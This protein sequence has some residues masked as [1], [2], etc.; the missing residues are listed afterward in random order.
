M[1]AGTPVVDAVTTYRLSAASPRVRMADWFAHEGITA[2]WHTYA[3]TADVRPETLAAHPW[4]VLRA[5]RHV[6]SIASAEVLMLSREA[7][8]WSLG[9][10]EADLLARAGRGVYDVDDAIFDD[11]SPIRRLMRF[12]RKWARMVQ[13]A[14][15]VIAG[16]DY[17][18]EHAGRHA[19]DVRMIPSCIEP[20][21]YRAKTQWSVSEVPRV[22]WLGSP[23][24]EHYLV[25]LIE[26]LARLHDRTGARLTL[27]SGPG[28]RRDLAPLGHLVDRVAWDPAT[29]PALLAMGDVAIGPLD[30]SPYARGKCAYKLLQ[31][32][33]TGLPMVASPVGANALALARFDG[34]PVAGVDD[35]A[36]ALEGV[37]T[38]SE[39]R[40]AARGRR[41]LVAV[42]EHYAFAAWSSAWRD[43]VLGQPPDA[44][45][46]EGGSASS[47]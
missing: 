22:V 15:V 10:V 30:D 17:L 34:V 28:E 42:R 39:A 41:A 6:R 43:A 24:T 2:R 12:P 4:R 1:T 25:D 5:E 38:E 16:N 33:A 26:P 47:P 46:G 18:A 32:A 31:Y 29:V 44:D 27:I 19:S 37:L 45:R 35:W 21:D 8:P 20:E 40:R 7:S 11:P 36:D 13:A 9:G 14:D 23:A 3:D